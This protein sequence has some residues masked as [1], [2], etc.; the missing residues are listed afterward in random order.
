MI[1]FPDV[2]V[3]QSAFDADAD[4]VVRVA[5]YVEGVFRGARYGDGHARTHPE[6]AV[7]DDGVFLPAFG[8]QYARSAEYQ[9]PFA[10]KAPFAVFAG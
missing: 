6:I 1:H 9:V 2:G 7:G 8:H 5:F 3:D 10:E 4:A